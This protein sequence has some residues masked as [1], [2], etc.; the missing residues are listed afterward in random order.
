[1]RNWILELENF[2][3]DKSVIEFIYIC[4]I[5]VKYIVFKFSV[6]V[7]WVNNKLCYVFLIFRIDIEDKVEN[8]V[9]IFLK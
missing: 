4:N 1:M 2:F 3:G 9:K 7:K 5:S 8:K 6:I